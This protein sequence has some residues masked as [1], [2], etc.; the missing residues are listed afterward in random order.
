MVLSGSIWQDCPD[1]VR[2]TGEYIVF[3]Q[4]GIIDHR[5]NVPVPV[6]Q[7]SAESEYNEA[8]TTGMSLSHF[9]ILNNEFLN[10]DIDV[11]P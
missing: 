11:V 3:Y 6:A 7:S 4:C 2:T 8:C 1:T 10:K 5:T 9:R